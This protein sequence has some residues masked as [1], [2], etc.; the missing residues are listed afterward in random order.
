M[1]HFVLILQ[2]SRIIPSRS[3]RRVLL[4]PQRVENEPVLCGWVH[5]ALTV[6]L[7]VPEERLKSLAS[8]GSLCRVG[9][10]ACCSCLT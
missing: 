1:L 6:C 5:L 2:R 10:L 3:V 9:W 4:G 7:V 8:G